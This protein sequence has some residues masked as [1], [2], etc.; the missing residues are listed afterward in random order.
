MESA[1]TDLI[2]EFVI[3]SQEGLANIEQQM[4]TIEAGGANVDADLV[5]AVFRTMHTIK[6]T[7]GFLGLD[8]IGALAHGLEE[9]LNGMRN[10]E[11]ATSSE[12]V[13]SILK[14]ADF[15]KG[16]IDSVETSNEA[17]IAEH[18]ALLHRHRPG[19]TVPAPAGNDPLAAEPVAELVAADAAARRRGGGDAQQSRS[20]GCRS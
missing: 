15:M 9:I 1:D 12:L 19:T 11:I 20:H 8:R 16:L 3:E 10:R 2:A 5:N 18:V 7:A 14:A 17:D 4:L 13:T 6:G